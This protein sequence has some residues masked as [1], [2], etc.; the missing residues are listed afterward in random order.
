MKK[1]HRVFSCSKNTLVQKLTVLGPNNFLIKPPCRENVPF[2]Q[3]AIFQT[4]KTRYGFSL[5]SNNTLFK[6]FFD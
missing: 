3:Q 5:A 1:T 4:Y 6:Q 2:S